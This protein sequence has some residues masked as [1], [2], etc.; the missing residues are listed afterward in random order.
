MPQAGSTFEHGNGSEAEDRRAACDSRQIWS[1]DSKSIGGDD[2]GRRTE[3]KGDNQEQLSPR[4]TDGH[5][6]GGNLPRFDQLGSRIIQA[7]RNVIR[8]GRQQNPVDDRSVAE[9]DPE[10]DFPVRSSRGSEVVEG[11]GNARPRGGLHTQVGG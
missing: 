9:A 10:A 6:D 5:G 3:D 11:A 1:A 4:P 7:K 8:G 2:S